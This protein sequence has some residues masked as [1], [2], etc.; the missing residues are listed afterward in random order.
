MDEI[1][2]GKGPIHCSDRNADGYSVLMSH[3]RGYCVSR[4]EVLGRIS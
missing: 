2:L 1:L 4:E 3:P